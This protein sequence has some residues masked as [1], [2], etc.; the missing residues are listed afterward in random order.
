MP[1]SIRIALMIILFI[2][3][4]GLHP[5]RGAAQSLTRSAQEAGPS[6]TDL[7]LAERYVP[8]LY[9]HPDEIYYPQPADVIL[10][11]TRIRQNVRL[12]FDTT[13]SN[14]FTL[15]DLFS[16]P[17]DESYFLDQWFGDTGSSEYGN[18]AAHKSIYESTISPYAGGLAPTTYA[19]VVRNENP[20]FIT[21]QYW[22]FYFYNDWFNKHEGDWELV[23]VVLKA[24]GQ[25]ES[26]IYSQH[27]GGVR[28]TWS[29]TPVEGDTHPVVYVARGSHANYFAADEVYPHPKV[30]GN[31]R[32]VLVDRTGTSDRTLPEVRL[33]P[34]RAELAADPLSWPGAEWLMFRG[35]WG[36][37]GIYGDFNGPYGPADK[38]FQWDEP[39]AW[40]NEQPIDLVT[41]YQNRLKV[42]IT[43]PVKDQVHIQ[44]ADL[45][46]MLL[47]KVESLD[48]LA[49]LHTNPPDKVMAQVVGAPG[50]QG[51]LSVSWPNP[52]SQVVTTTHF[53]G[54]Q[55]DDLGY[56]QLELSADDAILE[57]PAGRV[58]SLSGPNQ[59][60]LQATFLETIKPIWDGPDTVLVGNTLPIHEILLGLAIALAYSLVPILILIGLLYWID[61]Y[62]K[63][64]VRMLVLA[65]F[66]GAIPALVVALGVQ[67]FFKL[68]PDIL[69]PNALQAVRLGLL[70]PVLE[71]I[72]K[73][74]GVLFIYW[75]RPKE[76][77]S[78]LDG[79]IYGAIVGFGFAFL[80]NFSRY[81]GNFIVLGYPAFNPGAIAERTVH[82]LDHGLYTAIFG[83]GLGFAT[84]IKNRRQFWAWVGGALLLAIVAH[85]LHNLLANSTVGLNV[86]S[87]MVTG[88]GILLLFVVAFWSLVQQRRL[89]RV[90]LQGLVN[91]SLYYSVQGPLGR[92]KAQW[93]TLRREGFRAWIQL[94]HLQGLC[95]GL[96]NARLQARLFPEKH[97]SAHKAET[98]QAEI[99][100]L[101][102]RMHLS[103]R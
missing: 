1:K 97:A 82:A 79:L 88:A 31:Q 28:R 19:H 90:E 15:Q 72:L 89:L 101:I 34:S 8:V 92:I 9:F 86:F 93:S 84:T 59:V 83:A 42:Q 50:T 35:R 94:R 96:A 47:P 30:I 62:Q 13:I 4:A 73:A 11:V 5:A 43:G 103:V 24:N 85:A 71:E 77:D 70:A 12:W 54:F 63:E 3:L 87:V 65:F 22:L 27:H 75:R 10:G 55:L 60:P 44:L 6:E 49:I 23:E 102:T 56:A 48:N 16:I 40:G 58:I 2:S 68:P 32:I 80:S 99:E 51:E 46:G 95:I 38:G 36:E 91:D 25:P 17:S 14:S 66:W 20:D 74:A 18:P 39:L 61:R 29:T 7:E 69:G 45:G 53:T 21:I 37:T 78:V 98:L 81:V 64:P 41:W 57:L 100:R 52:I 33:I 67:L 76:V 26:V